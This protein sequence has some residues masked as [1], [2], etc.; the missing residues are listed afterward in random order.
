[1]CEHSYF[2]R[3]VLGLEDSSGKAAEMGT[4]FHKLAECLGRGKLHYQNTGETS[5]D[6]GDE[7]VGQI[8]VDDIFDNKCLS[9]IAKACHTYYSSLSDH[10]WNDK[11]IIT[12]ISW[13]NTMVNFQDGMFDPR[14]RTIAFIEK[15]FDIEIKKDW[16][17]YD[18]K[19]GDTTVSGYLGIKGTID[20]IEWV[21]DDTYEVCDYKT[22]K[23]PYNWATGKD[24]VLSDFQ[25]D[26]QLLIYYYALRNLYPDKHFLF[27][28]Y[29]IVTGQPF[30]VGFDDR[31]Y[32]KAEEMIRKRFEEIKK[33]QYPDLI[34]PTKEKRQSNF[35]CSKLCHFA[36]N[37]QPGT[38]ISICEF[39][40]NKVKESSAD[41]VMVEFGNINKLRNYQDGG[42]GKAEEK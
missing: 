28:V 36:K 20:L 6:V 11:D 23:K 19:I 17:K 31:D 39:F 34:S 1:M 29:Y 14:K 38:D 32:I 10:S 18:Y 24:K 3:Y 21:D 13:A 2:L 41:E 40:Q 27:T 7:Y 9:K 42:G 4:A 30:T 25:K 26:S 35:K 33:N 12:I 15:F 16:A 5:C 8:L 22:G 37:N